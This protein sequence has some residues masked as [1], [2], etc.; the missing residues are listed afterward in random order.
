VGA[1]SQLNLLTPFKGSRKMTSHFSYPLTSSGDVAGMQYIPAPIKILPPCQLVHGHLN[2]RFFLRDP[3][4]PSR[5]RCLRTEEKQ[6]KYHNIHTIYH[7]PKNGL[8]VN[9]WIDNHGV[10]NEGMF[11]KDK[12]KATIWRAITYQKLKRKKGQR[13]RAYLPPFS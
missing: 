9:K 6:W 11:Y 3:F 5:L 2:L 13:S 4:N 8:Y 7:M 1:F 10:G 12:E